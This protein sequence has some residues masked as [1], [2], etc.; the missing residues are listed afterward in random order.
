MA[1]VPL[2]EN[3]EAFGKG[4]LYLSTNIIQR[5]VP[6][7]RIL[8]PNSTLDERCFVNRKLVLGYIEKKD[9]RCVFGG[10]LR[11]LF[12]AKI[13]DNTYRFFPRNVCDG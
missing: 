4:T 10:D 8:T 13:Y 9:G 5:I 12:D 1:V 11:L 3:G 6:I 7:E 2:K